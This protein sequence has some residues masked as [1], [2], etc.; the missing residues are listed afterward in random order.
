[1]H[2]SIS[3]FRIDRFFEDVLHLFDRHETTSF[4]VEPE[5]R[6]KK[7]KRGIKKEFDA[8]KTMTVKNIEVGGL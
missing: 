2:L 1:M 7:R 8:F 5:I 3:T 4:S 6:E